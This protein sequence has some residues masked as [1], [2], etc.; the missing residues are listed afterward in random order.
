[1]VNIPLEAGFLIGCIKTLVGLAL[2]LMLLDSMERANRIEI[3]PFRL[4]PFSNHA[5]TARAIHSGC[6]PPIPSR[7][8]GETNE[9][10]SS[11]LEPL[12]DHFYGKQLCTGSSLYIV[13]RRFLSL[14]SILCNSILPS[15]RMAATMRGYRA[16]HGILGALGP[17]TAALR[18]VAPPFYR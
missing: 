8:S 13:C 2:H 15:R 17:A 12:F 5:K 1:M 10:R 7:N 9:T 3:K 18:T 4:H 16:R 6:S 11:R 14:I